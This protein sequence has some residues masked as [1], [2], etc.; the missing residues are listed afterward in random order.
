MPIVCV[1]EDAPATEAQP[2]SSPVRQQKGSTWTNTLFGSGAAGAVAR[3]SGAAAG[4]MGMTPSS[5]PPR[6]AATVT[7]VQ[8]ARTPQKLPIA[9]SPAPSPGPAAMVAAA[10]TAAA[11]E[12]HSPKEQSVRSSLTATGLEVPMWDRELGSS[13]AEPRNSR[14]GSANLLAAPPRHSGSGAFE[15]M[16]ASQGS[17]SALSPRHSG[18]GAPSLMP[19]G[20]GSGA[21]L[22]RQGS[23]GSSN[24]SPRV[25]GNQLAPLPHGPSGLGRGRLAPV[26]GLKPRPSGTDQQ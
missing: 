22:T 14:P 6:P 2:H 9:L 17:I 20:S 16:R 1:Q 3:A 21:P 26:E 12:E 7:A 15:R 4:S 5:S 18:S 25:A 8:P 10:A 23:A 19:R 13:T 24:T 11:S